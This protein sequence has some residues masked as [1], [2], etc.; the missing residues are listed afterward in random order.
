[1]KLT[2][3]TY[4]VILLGF[5]HLSYSQSCGKLIANSMVTQGDF[6]VTLEKHNGDRLTFPKQ[7]GIAKTPFESSGFATFSLSPGVH[8]FTGYAICTSGICNKS[9]LLGGGDADGVKFAIDIEAGKSYKIAAKPALKASLIPGK[10]FD[11]FVMTER[12]IQCE[13]EAKAA[14]T[15]DHYNPE[16]VLVSK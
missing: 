5:S 15:N 14:L 9:R 1:M 3:V 2:T 12:E 11:I 10:R 16:I 7:A 8:E 13:G 6:A 4:L